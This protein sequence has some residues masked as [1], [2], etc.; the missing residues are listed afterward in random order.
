MDGAS[1]GWKTFRHLA[2]PQLRAFPLL[3]VFAFLQRFLVQDVASSG[4]KG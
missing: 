3:L 2:L 4:I 1:P